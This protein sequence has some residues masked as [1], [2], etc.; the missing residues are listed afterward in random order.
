MLPDFKTYDKAT[1][2]RKCGT[3]TRTGIKMIGTEQS[4]N[5]PKHTWSIYF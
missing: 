4:R 1:E 2:I 3:G 5:R